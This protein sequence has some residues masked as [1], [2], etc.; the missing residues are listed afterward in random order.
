MEKRQFKI[1]KVFEKREGESERGKW[2]YQDLW[3]IEDDESIRYP[4]EFLVTVKGEDITLAAKLKEGDTIKCGM[5][6][7]VRE[8]AVPNTEKVYHSQ[9]VAGWG[10]E[11][12]QLSAL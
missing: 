10:V 9:I 8:Y 5:Q 1:K 3:L 12:V 4:D 11:I 6:F 7:G 2:S